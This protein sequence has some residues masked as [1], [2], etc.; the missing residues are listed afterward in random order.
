MA[1]AHK[2]TVVTNRCCVQIPYISIY[3]KN[4]YPDI[5]YLHQLIINGALQVSA[6]TTYLD[7]TCTKHLSIR[8]YM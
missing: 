6:N 3:L 1:L 2:I 5:L 4:I 8:C 7:L